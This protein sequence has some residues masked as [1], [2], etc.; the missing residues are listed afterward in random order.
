MARYLMAKLRNMPNPMTPKDLMSSNEV[1][2]FLGVTRASIENY[3]MRGWLHAI[4][5][6]NRRLLFVRKEV[7]ALREELLAKRFKTD[8]PLLVVE[9]S[10]DDKPRLVEASRPSLLDD[11]APII[12]SAEV[13]EAVRQYQQ[14][15]RER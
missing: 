4:R 14:S 8:N 3:R 12:F 2:A 7:E 15:K 13:W 11:P 1:A 9:A 10:T 5:L 6:A